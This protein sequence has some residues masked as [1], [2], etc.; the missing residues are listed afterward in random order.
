[1]TQ[2][3]IKF[4]FY[5]GGVIGFLLIAYVI[6]KNCLTGSMGFKKKT[7]NLDIEETLAISPKKT[8][9][10]VKA[11]N[12]KFLIASDSTSTTLL[13]K[14]NSDTTE[15]PAEFIEEIQNETPINRAEKFQN[16]VEDQETALTRKTIIK[17]NSSVIKSMLKKL[18]N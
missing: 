3:L 11:F 5:T 10:I 2:Y 15:I 6:A 9:H 13:A 14:L 8:L 7:G 17:S 16:I 4:I 18:D 1:M 12:E